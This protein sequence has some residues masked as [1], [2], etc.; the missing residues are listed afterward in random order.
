MASGLPIARAKA[1]ELVSFMMFYPCKTYA[2]F[3]QAGQPGCLAKNPNHAAAN[4]VERGAQGLVPLSY[5]S[6]VAGQG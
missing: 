4:F 3:W 1:R 2:E 5:I 6:K